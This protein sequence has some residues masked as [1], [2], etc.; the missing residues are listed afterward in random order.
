M[1]LTKTEIDMDNKIARD[2]RYLKFYSVLL[3]LALGVVLLTAFQHNTKFEQIDAQRINILEPNGK[4][5]LAIS[6]KKF[7]PAPILNG[8]V[9][10]RSVEVGP[11]MIFFNGEGEEQGGLIWNGG[12]KDGKYSAGAGLLFDQYKQDQ[13]VG[14]AYDDENGK[15]SAGLTV[16]DHP[17]YPL[18]DIWDKSQ[19]IKKMGPG[20]EK[21]QAMKDLRKEWGSQRVFVGKQPDKSAVLLLSD[22]KGNTRLKIEVDAG[23]DPKLVFLDEKGNVIYTLPPTK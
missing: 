17:E 10:E 2:V 22:A 9:M 11:G 12:S 4:I 23:G 15:R 19:V 1:E 7:F 21:D 5:D 6:N 20:P 8:K 18:T 16:W 13:T 14:F 3:T